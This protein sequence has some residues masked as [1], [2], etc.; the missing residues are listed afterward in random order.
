MAYSNIVALVTRDREAIIMIANLLTFPL[1]FV[2]SA[3]LTLDVLP[4]GFRPSPSSIPSP[5]V[6]TAS[7]R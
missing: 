4:S 6:S 1:L 2:S 3:F 7:R 5:A